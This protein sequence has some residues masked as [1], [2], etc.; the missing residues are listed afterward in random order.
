MTVGCVV[1]FQELSCLI[2]IESTKEKCGTAT[3]VINNFLL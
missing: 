3:H 2:T 1:A